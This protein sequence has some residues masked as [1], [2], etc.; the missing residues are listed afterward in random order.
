MLKFHAWSPLFFF[1]ATFL[2]FLLVNALSN[3]LEKKE[4]RSENKTKFTVLFFPFLV[5]TSHQGAKVLELQLQYQSF[6]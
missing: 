3:P 4:A 1:S 5:D 2:S 6:Q